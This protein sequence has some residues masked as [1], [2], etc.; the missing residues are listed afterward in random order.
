M[1]E[2]LN[3]KDPTL[4]N[5][6]WQCTQNKVDELVEAVNALTKQVDE[7]ED[8]LYGLEGDDDIGF[9]ESAQ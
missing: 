4:E 1:I 2:R 5:N 6:E 8:H 7:L 9:T 3:P